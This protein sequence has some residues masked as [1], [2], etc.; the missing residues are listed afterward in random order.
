M[1]N[2]RPSPDAR[3]L[4]GV[5]E[6]GW[7]KW[8]EVWVRDATTGEVL[9]RREFTDALLKSLEWE[10]PKTFLVRFGDLDER[11]EDGL[12]HEKLLRCDTGLR[13]CTRVL[14]PREQD[15]V[16]VASQPGADPPEDYP[17]R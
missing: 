13:H 3:H 8:N 12:T 5:D 7:N 6:H 16:A 4:A 11:R 10:S 2:A 14:T 17:L 15:V 1:V 9:A